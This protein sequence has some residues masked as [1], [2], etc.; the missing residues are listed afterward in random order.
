MMD[1]FF[2]KNKNRPV[3]SRKLV[4]ANGIYSEVGGLLMVLRVCKFLELPL[5]L[6]GEVEDK[7]YF[8]ACFRAGGACLK[9]RPSHQRNDLYN[10]ARVFVCN[11]SHDMTSVTEAIQCGCYVVCT[12]LNPL[13]EKYIKSGLWAYEHHNKKD[14]EEKLLWAYSSNIVQRNVRQ[15][16]D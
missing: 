2:I 16:V 8:D 15:D 4:Y 1:D 14:F 13:C 12:S 11:S 10:I 5:I 3:W 6:S 7:S 9:S